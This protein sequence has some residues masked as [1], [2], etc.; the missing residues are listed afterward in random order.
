MW[1]HGKRSDMALSGVWWRWRQPQIWEERGSASRLTKHDHR[2]LPGCKN[3]PPLGQIR[4]WCQ[5]VAT[6]PIIQL[7]TVWLV[8]FHRTAVR[9]PILVAGELVA[10]AAGIAC[11]SG[12][13]HRKKSP[14]PGR[15]IIIDYCAALASVTRWSGVSVGRVLFWCQRTSAFQ[16]KP[17]IPIDVKTVLLQASVL[18]SSAKTGSTDACKKVFFRCEPHYWWLLL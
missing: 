14:P 12:F 15:G 18:P 2:C 8:I 11:C 7:V 1:L 13:I 6:S 5:I 3:T 17:A 9:A 10:P 4:F 16:S